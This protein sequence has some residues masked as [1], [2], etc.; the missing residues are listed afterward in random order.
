DFYADIKDGYDLGT[1]SADDFKAALAAYALLFDDTDDRDI[2]FSKVK[3]VAD[4][5]GYASDTK[6]YKANPDA[7]KGPLS[8]VAAMIRI[9]ITN[10]SQTPDLYTIMQVLGADECKKRIN[11]A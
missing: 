10:R 2:W 3:Q 5:I 11:K 8:D 1:L 6:L 9:A 4:K 7:Y